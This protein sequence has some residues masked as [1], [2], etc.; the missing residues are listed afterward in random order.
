MVWGSSVDYVKSKGG[1]GYGTDA[2]QGIARYAFERM[3]LR[4]LICLI[5]GDRITL[6]H[7]PVATSQNLI[8][9]LIIG[10]S[11]IPPLARS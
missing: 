2:A 9:A 4:R 1:K 3:H 8:V 11:P 6:T 7:S 10:L 5:D